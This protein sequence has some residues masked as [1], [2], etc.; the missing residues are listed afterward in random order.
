MLGTRLL[1]SRFIQEASHNSSVP[2]P[3]YA[4]GWVRKEIQRAI[5][6][7]EFPTVLPAGLIGRTVA[8][9]RTLDEHADRLALAAAALGLAP[10]TVAALYRQLDVPITAE[11]DELPAPGYVLADPE[12]IVV[13]ADFTVAARAAL[14]RMPPRQAD[15]LILRYGLDGGS[16]RS[17]REIGRRLAVSGHT[18][19]ALVERAQAQ[20]RQLLE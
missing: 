15:A 6:R 9:R 20:M 17:Y 3:A 4:R 12:G 14:A 16:E 8:L 13:A 11:E 2:F 19:R 7:Q 10:A 5:A 18:A 1:P